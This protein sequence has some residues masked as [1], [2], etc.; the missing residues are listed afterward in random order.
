MTARVVLSCDGDEGI[1]PCRQAIPVGAVLTGGQA[2][3]IAQSAGWTSKVFVENELELPIV[4]LC[5]R[6]SQQVLKILARR[7]A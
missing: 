3:R 5:P 1:Y 7:A 6:C 2:R 4:D